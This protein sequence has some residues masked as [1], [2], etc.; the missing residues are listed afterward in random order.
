[1]LSIDSST[2]AS[3]PITVTSPARPLAPAMV[4]PPSETGTPRRRRW[5][6]GLIVLAISAVGV[7]AVATWWQDVPPTPRAT[8]T[9]RPAPSAAEPMASEPDI[10]TAAAPGP[11]ALAPPTL[12][13]VGSEPIARVRIGRRAIE[14]E[15]PARQ[16]ELELTADEQIADPVLEVVSVSGKVAQVIG[17]GS[18]RSVVSFPADRAR[19]RPRQRKRTS[20]PPRATPA[21]E[22]R[23]EPPVLFPN[24]YRSRP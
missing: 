15:P 5:G 8:T 13:L 6:P 23:D 21:A 24:P 11:R 3:T 12:G 2:R 16:V 9:G 19:P 14:I 4:N 1:L 20:A 7:V 17:G 10:A 22:P 18:R